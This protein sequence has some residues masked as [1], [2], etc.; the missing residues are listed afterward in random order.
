MYGKKRL[1]LLAIIFCVALIAGSCKGSKGNGSQN[2]NSSAAKLARWVAQF[3]SPLAQGLTGNDLA[4][5]F[6]YSSISVLSPSLVYVG[7]DMRNPKI[8]EDRVGVVVKTTDGGQTWAETIL[9]Q[10]GVA[11]IRING[12][13]FVDSETGFAVGRVQGNDAIM[14]KTTDGGKTWAF[15]RLA[16]LKQ[17]PTCIF[18]ADAE[19]GWMG[20]ATSADETD[21]E[22][23]AEPGGPSDLLATTDGGKTWQSQVRLPVTIYDLQFLDKQTG[24]ASGSNGAVYHTTNSGL[25]WDK[26]RTELEP[27]EAFTIPGTE[28]A[29][30]FDMNG[31]SFTDADHGY[32]VARSREEEDTGRVLGTS[33]GGEVWAKQRI[34]ADSGARD[35][36]FLNPNEGWV[37]TDKGSYIYHTVD[38]NRTWLSEKKDLEFDPPLSRLGAADAQH[39]WAVGG[40]VILVRQSD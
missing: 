22:E 40:G 33:N 12:M 29:K 30:K 26:Q 23:E 10:P 18:M 21:D 28:G 19:T 9:E 15:S 7:G 1:G 3:R 2:T 11:M 17:I 13:A 36:L 32:A 20:G 34:V 14:F 31:I 8:K 16:S 35:V 6:Y 38:S 25:S 37:L 5:N 27:G 39:V 24:W 4:E